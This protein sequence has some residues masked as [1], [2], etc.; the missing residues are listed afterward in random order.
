MYNVQLNSCILLG[1]KVEISPRDL[2]SELYV[3]LTYYS[4]MNFIAMNCPQ[5]KIFH[6]NRFGKP[7]CNPWGNCSMIYV[8]ISAQTS[9]IKSRP[10]NDP[11][12][13]KIT[14]NAQSWPNFIALSRP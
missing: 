13:P 4:M 9:I 7:I 1:A 14:Q 5:G 8:D 3:V 6:N 10:K 2:H 11:R 12:C